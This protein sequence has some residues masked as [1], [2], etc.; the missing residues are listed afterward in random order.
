M[1]RAKLDT[2]YVNPTGQNY[3]PKTATE[4]QAALKAAQPGAKITLDAGVNYVGN[5][6]LPQKQDG[7]PIV[8]CS[9]QFGA[10]G[11]RVAPGAGFAKISTPNYVAA[12][13]TVGKASNYR[14]VGLEIAVAKG[15]PNNGGIVRVG[16]GAE[17]ALD[18]LPENIVIDRCY[19]HGNATGDCSRAVAANGKGV[20]V[21][22]SY[23]SEIHGNGFDTQAVCVWN[24]TLLKVVNC[25]LEAAGENFLTG[26]ADPK[27]PGLI[28]SDIEFRN[29]TCS[30]PLTWKKGHASFAGIEWT[31]KN[32]LELKNSQYVLI[33]GNLFEH[34]WVMGQTGYAILLKCANQDNTAPQSVTADVQF[35]NNTVR[36]SVNAVNLL[37]RDPYNQSGQMQRLK[38]INNLFYEIGMG[39]FAGDGHFVTVTDCDDLV[40]ENN[41]AFH[42]GSIL[43]AYG[44][45]TTRLGFRRNVVFHNL[46]GVKGD[47]AQS[48]KDT[49]SKFFPASDFSANV[50]IGTPDSLKAQY[51]SGNDYV[52]QAASVGF[53]DLAN[54]DYALRA[55]SPYLGRGW[56][57]TVAPA[58][59]PKPSD[60]KTRL[61]AKVRELDALIGELP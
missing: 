20:S 31:V 50:V 40:F 59:A 43:N 44:A 2:R 51:P 55:D 3:N 61:Q 56:Q 1:I 16:T 17:T 36:R 39:V 12:L 11:V 4:L 7:Q 34:C 9:S 46:Y 6:E 19:L 26:G 18:Q 22:D 8:V 37:G 60:L 5:F 35:S 48:G 38:F 13:Q 58:P 49:L 25:Y 28:P 54:G 30:K 10:E 14:F 33:D 45:P 57:S 15:V 23:I 52:D 24:G 53:K 41:T 21:V 42:A 32:L 47:S 29:N 27:I